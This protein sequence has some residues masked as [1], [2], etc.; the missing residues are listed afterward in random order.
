MQLHKMKMCVCSHARAAQ[1]ASADHL[2]NY[3]VIMSLD[4][5]WSV[6]REYSGE[7]RKEKQNNSSSFFFFFI[8]FV[9]VADR[10]T[11]RAVKARP[12]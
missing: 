2:R 12:R 3:S 10:L 11:E 6:R 8:V 9:Y 7:K 1:R 5:S 4:T